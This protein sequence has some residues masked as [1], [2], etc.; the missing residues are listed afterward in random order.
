MEKTFLVHCDLSYL[1]PL[2][3]HD[4]VSCF[5]S[6]SESPWLPLSSVL[7]KT[8]PGNPAVVISGGCDEYNTTDE[9]RRLKLE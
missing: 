8:S 6:M 5:S 1:F 7:I 9:D 4:E 2:P 3:K